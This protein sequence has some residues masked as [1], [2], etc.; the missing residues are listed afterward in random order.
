MFDALSITWRSLKDLWDEFPFLILLNL[1]WV[2]SALL[3]AAPVFGLGGTNLFLALALTLLLGLPLP[4]VS[5]GI[6]FVANQ[7]T[8][9]VSV[10][11]GTFFTGVRRYWAKSLLVALVNLV[12][13][14]LIGANLR[15]YAVVLQGV[16]TNF[17]LSIWLVVGIFWLLAQLFWFPMILE[18]KDEK[19]FVALRHAL[20]MVI[21]TP[22]FAV[23]LGVIVVLLA[24]LSVILTV[25][26]G[27][28]LAALLLLI[29]NHA[30]RS[31]LARI[32]KKPYQ[33]VTREE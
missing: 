11:W 28:M 9:G 1:L 26:A 12:V 17:V 31:R 20:A 8:R 10:N 21:I 27:F 24:V 3:A 2:A 18:L 25:P 23:A 29:S 33:P 30:T 16:W 4:V 13:L 32:Q 15:F 22:G 6:C 7:L 5:G 14:A 19:T